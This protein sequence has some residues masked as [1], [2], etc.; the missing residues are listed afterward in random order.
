MPTLG[1]PSQIQVGYI[2]GVFGIKGW[3][4]VFSYCR[5]KEKIF[6]YPIWV[7][8]LDDAENSYQ[9]EQGKKH[10]AA[11]IAKLS[12]VATRTI[13]EAL[14]GAKI[15]VPTSSL[16]VLSDG[17]FYWYQ[18]FGLE[19]KNLQGLTMGRV[20]RLMETGANDVIVVETQTNPKQILIPY[21]PD[22]V[23]KNIDLDKSLMIVDWQIDY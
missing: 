11:L 16:E 23:I 17:E 6:E 7:L 14:G 12:G 20:A 5:P 8:R 13:S 9:L 21:V 15:W 19:V 2:Q 18:L 4:K 10:G 22:K 1:H 3:L